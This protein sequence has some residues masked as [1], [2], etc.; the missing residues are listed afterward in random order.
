[1]F[2]HN[3][4]SINKLR[5][6]S[7]VFDFN[8]V[9]VSVDDPFGSPSKGLPHARRKNRFC[10]APRFLAQTRIQPLCRTISRQSQDS[11]FLLF[12]PVS[13]HGLCAV[14]LSRESSRYRDLSS[15]NA[16]QTVSLGHPWSCFAQHSRRRQ[17]DSGLADLRRFCSRAHS[18][19]KDAVCPR[20]LWSR[21]GSDRLCLRF[22][23]GRSVSDFVSHGPNSVDTRAP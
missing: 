4:Q 16:V 21:S 14:D 12:R 11:E 22:H 3:R 2:I 20:R 9:P 7:V 13:L 1:M 5:P 6:V 18:E 10:S 19:G 15:C 8:A 23:H 17:R